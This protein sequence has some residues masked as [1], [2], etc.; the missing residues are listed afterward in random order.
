M[1]Y[2]D[3]INNVVDGIDLGKPIFT[4]RFKNNDISL[5]EGNWGLNLDKDNFIKILIHKYIERRFDKATKKYC[6]NTADAI[7]EIEREVIR[8]MI[9]I[10]IECSPNA[11][12]RR[13]NAFRNFVY[14][15][16]QN[17]SVQEFKNSIFDI[18]EYY[19][20]STLTETINHTNND[21]HRKNIYH[22]LCLME[23]SYGKK[24]GN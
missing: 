20:N 18:Y 9:D 14:V 4:V 19:L 10:F 15:I 8:K 11:K 1:S 7:K 21:V 2:L 3:K 5:D 17:K 6:T 23:K 13:T 22:L 12:P 16:E 24:T